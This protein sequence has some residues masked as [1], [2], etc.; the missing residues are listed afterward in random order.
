MPIEYSQDHT[1]RLV[2]AGAKANGFAWSP[3]GAP[4]VDLTP[5]PKTPDQQ[6]SELLKSLESRLETLESKFSEVINTFL[7]DTETPAKPYDSTSETD[8]TRYEFVSNGHWRK[9]SE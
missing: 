8:G 5:P 6:L 4:K 1:L 9:A 7:S 3:F 2:L